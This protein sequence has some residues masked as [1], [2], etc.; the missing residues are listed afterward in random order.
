MYAAQIVNNVVDQ[1]IVGDASWATQNLGGEWLQLETVV[2]VGWKY[3]PTTHQ[4]IPP[5][6]EPEETGDN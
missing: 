4:F 1:V 2:G 3:D 5:P 6:P